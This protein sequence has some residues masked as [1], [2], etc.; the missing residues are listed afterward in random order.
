MDVKRYHIEGVFSFTPRIFSDERGSFFES[1]NQKVF[2]EIAGKEILFVQDNQSVSKK[3]VLRGIH[4]QIPPYAQGKLVRV[5][6]GKALDIAVDLRK[7]SPTY[8]QH[9]FEE[10]S[11]D[12][13]RVLYIPEGFGHGFSALED[14]TIFFY[15]CTNF[16]SKESERCI[17][18]NDADL[19]IDWQIQNPILSEKDNEGELFKNFNSPF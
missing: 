18:F 13:N 19:K 4:F 10:L 5:I 3:N 1:F 12:N 7:N 16:Y 17:F 14:N 2:N 6:S 11:A 8:G 15:K 9:I